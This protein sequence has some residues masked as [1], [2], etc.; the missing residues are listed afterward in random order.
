MNEKNNIVNIFFDLDGTLTD[1]KDGITRCIQ[2]AL[3]QL[4]VASPAADQLEWCIGP[5]LHTS[6]ALLLETNER[7]LLE[8]AISLYR[9]R[10]SERGLFENRV[11]PEVVPT[12]RW[13]KALGV[14]L[15]LATSKP[16]VFAEQIIDHFS[17]TPFFNAVYGSELDGQLSDKGELIAYILD[18]EH[19][20]PKQT[21]M[22]G[23]RSHDIIG[24]KKNGIKTAGVSYGYGSREELAASEPDFT[25]SVLADLAALIGLETAPPRPGS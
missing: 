2:Y 19:L 25:V 10:F 17:L 15:F 11:Y 23:D 21:L 6:F 7:A 5:P 18:T 14:H 9:Q 13:I 12:L 16:K 8:N 3:D 20:D 22:V 1:P 24:G 4:G